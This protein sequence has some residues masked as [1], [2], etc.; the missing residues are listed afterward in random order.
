V[1]LMGALGDCI[2]LPLFGFTTSLETA[3]G[4]RFLAGIFNGNVGMIPLLQHLCRSK[5]ITSETDHHCTR[6]K[7]RVHHTNASVQAHLCQSTS[8]IKNGSSQY[9]TFM[10]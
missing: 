6:H 9:A 3:I 5:H 8:K 4:M 2:S 7:C 10:S 1:L